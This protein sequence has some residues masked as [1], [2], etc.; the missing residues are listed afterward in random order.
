MS[1]DLSQVPCWKLNKSTWQGHKP[2][3][4]VKTSVMKIATTLLGSIVRHSKRR[5]LWLQITTSQHFVF[6]W[7]LVQSCQSNCRY[8]VGASLARQFLVRCA[9]NFRNM[10]ERV[11]TQL[12]SGI[13]RKKGICSEG[14]PQN[15]IIGWTIIVG[16]MARIIIQNMIV[17]E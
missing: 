4:Y 17:Q 6:D 15:C 1:G 9:E 8:S 10:C 7:Y 11:S 13:D 5:S 2:W 14:W 3:V 12:L 16:A